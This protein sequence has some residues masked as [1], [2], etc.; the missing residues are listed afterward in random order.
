MKHKKAGIVN[1]RDDVVR[2]VL[3]VQ[4]ADGDFTNSN[5]AVDVKARLPEMAIE[6]LLDGKE[7]QEEFILCFVS[8]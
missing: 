8:S 6:H 7:E 4:V 3:R 2:S 5:R 1:E